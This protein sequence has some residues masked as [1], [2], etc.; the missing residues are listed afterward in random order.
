MM[1]LWLLILSF[2]VIAAYRSIFIDGL[3]NNDMN[4]LFGA[5]FAFSGHLNWRFSLAEGFERNGNNAAYTS[6]DGLKAF[7]L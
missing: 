4:R 2:W 1:A 6:S 3:K 7:G 5:V